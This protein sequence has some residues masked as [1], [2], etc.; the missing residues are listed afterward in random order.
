LLTAV[1]DASTGEVLFGG[2]DTTKFEGNLTT[3]PVD[4]RAGATKAR[5]FM[6]TLTS[7]GLTNNQGKSITLTDDN[8]AIPVLFDTGTTYTYLPTDL[9]QEICSQVGAQINDRTGV[10]IV[11]CDIRN[12]QGTVDY[13]F[14]GAV[15]PVALNELVVDA[16]T[17][18]GRPAK[19]SDGTPLCYFGILDA[20]SDNNVLVRGTYFVGCM[21]KQG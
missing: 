5:E 6:I 7:L 1:V 21:W 17:Y 4:K 8:F 18:D 12:Y 3:I 14:S 11:P 20:G 9:F 15:I 19:Y 2:V 16:Y 13:S 10:P